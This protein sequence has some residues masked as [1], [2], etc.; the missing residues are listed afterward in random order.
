VKSIGEVV[1][2]PPLLF[3]IS[4]RFR[5]TAWKYESIAYRLILMEV[6]ALLQTMYLTATALELRGCALGC[7][8]SDHF[9]RTVG[10]D[11]FAETSVGEFLLGA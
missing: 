10:T 9:A 5:K 4:A 7:E 8:D 1:R 6:G 3:I 2:N 11:Y